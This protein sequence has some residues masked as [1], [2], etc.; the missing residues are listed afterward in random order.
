MGILR[1]ISLL[2]KFLEGVQIAQAVHIFILLQMVTRGKCPGF[3][4]FL[5]ELQ[6]S[7]VLAAQGGDA[8]PVVKAFS[9]ILRQKFSQISF[10]CDKEAVTF[11]RGGISCLFKLERCQND[12]YFRPLR[13]QLLSLQKESF[14]LFTQAY[15]FCRIALF[16][17]LLCLESCQYSVAFIILRSLVLG[18][19][20]KLL[21]LFP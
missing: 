3:S 13:I 1:R 12:K 8:G 7:F 15:F 16:I 18:L 20:E 11:L 19:K 10:R 4:T 2:Q 21:S 9:A 17:G 5:Q 6:R 14:S